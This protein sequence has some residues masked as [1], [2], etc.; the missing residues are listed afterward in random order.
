MS[1]DTMA[2]PAAQDTS[3]GLNSPP[4]SNSALKD[5]GSDSELSDLEPDI[6]INEKLEIE[7]DHISSGGVPVFKPTMEEFVDFTRY[8][9]AVNKY[10][11]RTGIVKVIPPA[12]WVAAQPRLDEA[13]K[14]VRVKEPIKQDIMGTG[15]TYR[16]ANIVHQRS[17]N[18][19]Q[20]RQLC[21]QSEHQ[22]PAKRG[23]RRAAPE[24]TT[25]ST[26]KSKTAG[27]SSTSGAKKRPGRPP[28]NKPRS[29]TV[30]Q[31]GTSTPDRLPTPVSPTMKPEDDND[32]VKL[33]QED[34]D[35]PN[36][37]RGGR[38]PKAISVSSRRK[39]NK[40]ETGVVDEAAFQDFKYELE[41]EDYSQERCE[42]LERNYWKTLTY[43]PPLYGA[44]MPGTLFDE[45]TT[46][47]NLGKLDN[48]LDVLGSKIPGVNTAYLYLGM[49]KATFAWHLEDVD[50]YSINY[51]HF[52]APKQWYSISQGDARRFEAAMKTIWPTDAKAC[53]QFLRHKTFL[54]SPSQLLSNYNIK[55][56]KI[57]HHPGEFV[58]TFP[59]GYHSGY[60][61]GYNCAEAVNFGLE[62]WLEYGRVAKKCECS[63]AQD[64]VWIDVHEI[65]RKLRGEET[66]DEETDD[67]EDE[68]ED[69]EGS[70]STILLTAPE[71]SGNVKPKLV[72]KKR[73]RPTNEKVENSNV[74]RIRMRI[75]APTR[76]PCI[77]CPNDIPSEPLLLTED[78]EKAHR[79]C[80]QYIPETS[81]L[82]GEKETIVDVKYID[83]ARLDLKC[84]YCRS[85][86]GACFQ[87]SQK[88]CTRAYHATCAAAAG[89][90]VEQGET[91]VFG[92]DGTEYKDWGIDFSCRFHR[93][94]RDKKADGDSLGEDKRLLKAG[95]DLKAGDV[96]QMQ[97]FK[98][99]IFAGTV[100]ENRSSEEMILVDIL[101]R[102]HVSDME[103]MLPR[104][105]CYSDRVEVEYKWLLVPDLAERRLQKPSSKAIPMP[106]SFKAKESLNTSKRQADDLPRAEDPF[107]EGCTWAEFK[108]EP[109]RHN[110]AQVR[111]DFSK[112]DQIWFYLGKNS[113]E[114]KAQFTEDPTKPRHNPKG[115]FLD[116]IPKP[117]PAVQRQSYSASHPT[118]FNSNPPSFSKAPIRPPQ[119][120][121]SSIKP[122]KPYV[123]KPRVGGEMYSVD[124]KAYNDQQK[125][126]QRSAP[127]PY[128]FGTDPQY[129]QP[130]PPR[131]PAQYAPILPPGSNS[132][133]RPVSQ[134]A[135]PRPASSLAT[136]RSSASTPRSSPAMPPPRY[137]PSMPASYPSYRPPV[138]PAQRPMNPFGSRPPSSS[139]KPNPFAKYSYLQKEHNRSPL[140]YKSPY[141]PGGGFMNGYQGSLQAHLQQTLF[142]NNSGQPSTP[143][144]SISSFGS[145]LRPYSSSSQSPVSSYKPNS[146]AAY[147]TY[148]TSATPTPAPVSSPAPQQHRATVP[149]EKDSV[150]LHPAIR[151]E[152]NSVVPQKYPTTAPSSSS[153]FNGSVLQPPAMY[154]RIATQLQAPYQTF[155][156]PQQARYR[157]HH[158][159]QAPLTQQAPQQSHQNCP[160][161]P[162]SP[163]N[164]YH[165]VSAHQNPRL[166]VSHTQY[167]SHSAP[168][169]AVSPAY[170]PISQT[171]GKPPQRSPDQ[172]LVSQQTPQPPTAAW[173]PSPHASF[174]QQ[175]SPAPVAA[176]PAS[177]V[178][179]HS[180]APM[181]THTSAKPPV[182]QD[183]YRSHPAMPVPAPYRS[184]VYYQ[185]QPPPPLRAPTQ[186]GKV[187]YPHQPYY[188]PSNS[189]NTDQQAG[190]SAPNQ[191]PQRRAFPDV[192]AD[193][194]TLV[195]KMMMALKRAPAT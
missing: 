77:L 177:I 123:Y 95:L 49:W 169:S 137:G 159:L 188:Q 10:G 67:E 134:M 103:H 53:D 7:P 164:G 66:E 125:F 18:L 117:A 32:S 176:T 82:A 25:K 40:R 114:A 62:S 45:R 109:I 99:D 168:M 173:K 108:C 93:S 157:T 189:Q 100:V 102:G 47:W 4:D 185:S 107:V 42:E 106:K 24:K 182:S 130:D 146:P 13:I 195:E 92:E 170:S 61:L 147:N 73:K 144:S 38:Q 192:P 180:P 161:P 46:S 163:H 37:V 75:K 11:M 31:D 43:A 153:Q 115:H 59:Y 56:N 6:D 28:K 79:M 104:L 58:I 57:V 133:A 171:Q 48:I 194:T 148:R 116:T 154:D 132:G 131:P 138:P 12:E 124:Q 139:S 113:T 21:E 81:I 36:K 110:P 190:A 175:Y 63:E 167:H 101:P 3:V 90:L 128:A 143:M 89:V 94:K 76:E 22:P 112:E 54:I 193:S 5:G 98:G 72:K 80:A 136:A 145:S 39:N 83:K 74:K 127:A 50:L 86:K 84:N 149:P 126:L 97:Y 174:A 158:E 19:P 34:Y 87:C 2:V 55:V 52:G 51:L 184:D 44:D 183:N 178:P 142:R 186:D 172:A 166:P 152:Y 16:Q 156:T 78:G 9:G 14:T 15:G 191:N 33:E 140:E 119:P 23:E 68:E 71:A 29:A 118:N 96:C 181:P 30:E 151:Q 88:K 141:R 27:P 8:M 70:K 122:E 60:N 41:G 26:P 91:P 160:P 121:T 120:V 105:T 165:P 135:A 155:S 64:S 111:I 85:R 150:Q 187:L 20:W 65:D 179:Q 162:P 17:Y 69:E 1:A 129:R 35:M